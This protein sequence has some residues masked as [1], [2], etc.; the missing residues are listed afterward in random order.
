M[1]VTLLIV[2]CT[3]QYFSHNGLV[4]LDPIFAL[5]RPLIG[6]RIGFSFRD[7]KLANR[8]YNCTGELQLFA[9]KC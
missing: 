1:I 7:M 6:N 5:Y 9:T 8:L 3:V 4:T 2:F